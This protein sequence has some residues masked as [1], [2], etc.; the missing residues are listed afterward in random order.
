[1]LIFQ[2][3][4]N[5][6]PVR[7]FDK[8]DKEPKTEKY[9]IVLYEFS[10]IMWKVNDTND[11]KIIQISLYHWNDEIALVIVSIVTGLLSCV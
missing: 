7:N 10:D 1:M 5:Q 11:E 4:C 6:I 9:S 2:D 3:S 8:I